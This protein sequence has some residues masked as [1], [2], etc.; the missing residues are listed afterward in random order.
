MKKVMTIFTSLFLMSCGVTTKLPVSQT[1]PAAD[2][3]VNVK[4]DKSKNY[5]IL[6]TAKNLASPNRVDSQYNAYVVWIN[7]K[8]NG[9]KNIGQ[10]I[11]SNA[12]TVKQKFSTAFI[13]TE[14]TITLEKSGNVSSMSEKVITTSKLN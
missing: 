4:Q 3:K 5:T 10:I 7:T 1:V 9:T 2:I 6:L 13:P 12:K 14:V 11:N 8:E